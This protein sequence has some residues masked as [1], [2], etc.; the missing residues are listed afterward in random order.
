MIIFVSKGSK[1][2]LISLIGF[3]TENISKSGSVIPQKE[4]KFLY[5]NFLQ[6]RAHAGSLVVQAYDFQLCCHVSAICILKS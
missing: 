4:R 5:I 6:Q 1:L 3:L 2:H